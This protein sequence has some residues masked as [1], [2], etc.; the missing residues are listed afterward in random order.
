[1][2]GRDWLDAAGR[3]LWGKHRGRTAADV[4]ADDPGYLRWVLREGESISDAD[5][6]VLEAYLRNPPPC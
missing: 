5:R 2:S 6:R 1:M 3:F 4:A